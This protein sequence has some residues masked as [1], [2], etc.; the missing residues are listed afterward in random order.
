[1]KSHHKQ[2]PGNNSSTPKGIKKTHDKSSILQYVRR[3]IEIGSRQSVH[4]LK[5]E[6]GEEDLYREALQYIVATNKMICLALGIPI[7][8][9]CRYKRCWQR[10]NKLWPV[11]EIY[12]P[13]SG[14]LA[15]TLTTDPAMV[16]PKNDHSN[17]Q[18]IQS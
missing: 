17:N 8:N 7:E 6:F 15:M 16:P 1:M 10:F 12:D 4:K 9:G 2:D 18:N 11:K 5:E 14:C 3:Q 13:L